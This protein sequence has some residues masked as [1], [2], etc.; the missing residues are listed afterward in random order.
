MFLVIIPQKAEHK[1]TFN[2][3]Y[4]AETNVV[5]DLTSVT[6]RRAYIPTSKVLNIYMFF[7][8]FTVKN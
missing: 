2:A 8:S 5:H 7:R 3:R 4:K 6:T 1:S